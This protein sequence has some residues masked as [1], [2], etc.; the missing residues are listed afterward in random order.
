MHF[1]QSIISGDVLVDIKSLMMILGIRS[2]LGNMNHIFAASTLDTGRWQ[3]W[4]KLQNPRVQ[5]P[6]PWGFVWNP[7]TSA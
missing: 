5:H 1:R 7:P 6:E 4:L 3:R 2:D